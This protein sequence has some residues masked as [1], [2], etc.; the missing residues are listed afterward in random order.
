MID[1][2]TEFFLV[3]KE[4]PS[5]SIPPTFSEYMDIWCMGLTTTMLDPA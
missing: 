3:K 5:L 2:V 4:D 1:I